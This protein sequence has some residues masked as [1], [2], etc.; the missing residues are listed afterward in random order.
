MD[1]FNRQTESCYEPTAP[2]PSRTIP[3]RRAQIN[4]LQASRHCS[5]AQATPSDDKCEMSKADKQDI[6]FIKAREDSANAF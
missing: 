1:I 5:Q 6:K 3:D 4:R 2:K